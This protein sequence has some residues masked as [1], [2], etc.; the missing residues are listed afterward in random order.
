[1]EQA[2]DK[3]NNSTNKNATA[4]DLFGKRGA[5]VAN[6]LAEN[7]GQAEALT[8]ALNDA[9]GA[10]QKMADEQLD[11]LQGKLTIL[12]S[13]WEGLILSIEDGEGVISRAFESIVESATGILTKFT[14]INEV[15]LS[16]AIARDFIR[17]N[18]QALEFIKTLD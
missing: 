11:T 7:V 3:I 10:A 1:M 9:G 13:A 6:I 16:G 2:F 14:D 4:M 17:S 18:E 8:E 5:T 12:N 15:G